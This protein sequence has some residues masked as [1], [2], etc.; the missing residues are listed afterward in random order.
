[1][2]SLASLIIVFLLTR[3]ASLTII[4]IFA[5]EAI[6][7]RWAQLIWQGRFF[8][9]LSDGKTPLFMWLLAPILQ[10]INNPL[11]AGR[12][13][14]VLS[15]LATL[16]GV[17]FLSQKLFNKRI[18]IISSFLVIF[19]PFLLFYDRMSLVD[20]LLTAL[21]VW[22]IKVA[23]DLFKKP[24]LKPAII[25]GLLWA[26]ALLTKPAALLFI[27]LTPTLLLLIP[28]KNW[29]KKIKK[30]IPLGALTG[31]I[32]I[33]IYN[34]QRLS[35]AF[36]MI[37]RR[38]ADYLRS[39]SDFLNNPLEFIPATLKVFFGWLVSYLSWPA[40]VLLAITWVLAL[41]KKS[42]K[43]AFLSILAIIPFII[44]ASVGKIVYPRYLLPIIPFIL[45]I[46]SWGLNNFKKI[47]S[48]L[49]IILIAVYWLKFDYL[50]LTNPALAPLDNWEKTQYFYEW[51]AGYGLKEITDYL[52]NIPQDQSVLVST[53]G[54]FGTLPNGLT[55]FFNTSPNIYIRGLG[56]PEEKITPAM[57]KALISNHQVYL[58]FNEHRLG[59]YNRSRLELIAEYPRPKN[60]KPQQKLLF[61]Q[62]LPKN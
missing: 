23:Y 37:N 41:K 55:I 6:Y 22:S 56:F 34:L 53:E 12:L 57:E 16:A 45:I 51:S 40:L 39:S 27:L 36:H 43:I 46:L 29:F 19:S 35:S 49:F 7:I 48:L 20:S 62:V 60:D 24:Q 1:M 58:V 42:K 21:I 26:A 50:L 33:G 44:Q 4:P 17:F 8:M 2:L 28:V 11:L 3:L 59:D 13:L 10:V 25:L 32:A 15:G 38:S 18:A 5:D 9:P 61:F 52:N 30:L 14:S 31:I 54:G 47:F